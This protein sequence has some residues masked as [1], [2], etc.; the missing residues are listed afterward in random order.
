LAKKKKKKKPTRPL[1]PPQARRPYLS[2]VVTAR[3][4]DHGGRLLERMQA[5]LDALLTQ[6]QGAALPLELIIVEWN[7][8]LDKPKLAKALNWPQKA[9]CTSVRIIEVP[10]DIHAEY[11]NSASLPLYQMIAKN[12]GIRRARGEFVLAT[13]IDILLSQELFDFLAQKNLEP[14]RMY[15]VDRYDVPQDL[16]FEKPLPDL[17]EYCKSHLIRVNKRE[18]T[19]S[20]VDNS[21]RWVVPPRDPKAEYPYVLRAP[22]HTNTCGDFTLAHRDIWRR[23]RAYPEYDAYS[24]HLDSIFCYMAHFGGA[25]ELALKPPKVAYHIEHEGGWAPEKSKEDRL[26]QS[27]AQRRIPVLTNAQFDA[28]AAR[29]TET[30]SPVITN[31]DDWGL[32]DNAL[33]EKNPLN[34]TWETK[35]PPKNKPAT[36]EI[37]KARPYLSL[38][39]AGRND[40]HGVGFI[41]RSQSCLD[42]LAEQ[43]QTFGLFAELIFV[44]WNTP[45]DRPPLG[46]MLKTPP[47]GHPLSVRFIEVP[48]ALHQRMGNWEKIPFFQM[49][50]KNVGIRRARG[51]FV[52]AF[53]MDVVLSNELVNF[54]AQKRLTPE[55][56]YRVDRHDIASRRLPKADSLEQLMAKLA[57]DIIRVHK[58]ENRPLHTNACGDFTLLARGKWLQLGGYPE[59]PRYSLYIDAV[60]LYM[61]F[62]AGLKEV[63]LPSDFRAYHVEHDNSWA[64]TT[65]PAENMPTL[66]YHK[67]M[68]PWYKAMLTQN[69]PLNPNTD[70]W[71]FAGENLTET[72]TESEPNHA[73]KEMKNKKIKQKKQKRS[74]LPQVENIPFTIFAVPKPFT[75]NTA[76]IQRNAIESWLSLNPAPEIILLGDDPGVAETA[77]ELGLI[78]IPRVNANQHG[79]PLVNHVFKLARQKASHSLMAYVNADIILT[80]D[81]SR[82]LS[83]TQNRFE[84]FLMIGQRWD[85][86]LDHPLDFTDPDWEKKLRERVLQKGS[87]HAPTGIDYFAFCN[88]PWPEIPPFA[89]GRMAWDN[90]L[91]YE[92]IKRGVP[93]VDATNLAFIV[94][95]N[96][97]YQHVKGGITKVW[98]GEEATHNRQLAGP[99]AVNGLTSRAPWE[100]SE[101]GFLERPQEKWS[102][103]A[104]GAQAVELCQEAVKLMDMGL[105]QEALGK[106]DQADHLSKGLNLLGL[107]FARAYAHMLLGEPEKAQKAA[108]AELALQPHEN[109]QKILDMINNGQT[110]IELNPACRP[111]AEKSA[112]VS[113]S[114]Q[115]ASLKKG[116]ELFSQGKLEEAEKVFRMLLAKNP[117]DAEAASDLGV[118]L[119]QTGR[120][121]ESIELLRKTLAANQYHR[122]AVWN[123]GQLLRAQGDLDGAIL[124]FKSYLSKRPD[125]REIQNALE[126]WTKQRT[127]QAA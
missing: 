33:P 92:P 27:L 41:E 57:A 65:A 85:L 82:A 10:P 2:V 80:G 35:S 116:E 4:D 52:L 114:N 55:C 3:N 109:A 124:T 6:A 72:L 69:R 102:K 19:K 22:L 17:L 7:P 89:L 95:Q 79:T 74:S 56:L 23:L 106:L 50:A 73:S 51:E 108:Q 63:E 48:P 45:A 123:L 49:V 83:Q 16:P 112:P 100:V 88:D 8:P 37:K 68:V 13:N 5:F 28:L 113:D 120:R 127:V 53:N 40:D 115:A 26:R 15:R 111:V 62:T 84:K 81:F 64:V 47:E 101:L 110:K 9:E 24:F 58:K 14:D 1:K 97:D 66:D 39:A 75:D 125:D 61:A 12:V 20:F 43:C 78:H 86:E 118:V 54:L 70:D 87:L 31:C 44:D 103:D 91:V 71:G 90:W 96:H 93:V 107:N 98:Y 60:L 119:W 121:Q 94:H 36:A 29:M 25:M 11:Q 105:P 18:G 126:Q 104:A 99:D 34:A 117:N 32:G 38:V 122:G 42:V 46:K 21:F 59:L 77:M 76:V 30:Q 67:D